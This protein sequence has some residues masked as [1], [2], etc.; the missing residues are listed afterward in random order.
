MIDFLG[1]QLDWIDVNYWFSIFNDWSLIYVI[2]PFFGIELIRYT[3]LRRLNKDLIFDSIANLITFGAFVVI[4]YI[5]GILAITKVYFWVH[6][7]LS[8]SHL[9][10]TWITIICCILLA[11][12]AYYWDHR[13]MHR[14]GLGWA[15]HTVHH[16]SLHF[17]MSVAYRFG[18]LDAIFP[19]IFSLPIVM[20]WG[21]SVLAG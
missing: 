20:L 6:E 14:I 19:I 11:D 4:E 8:L 12:F 10:L 9:P 16:S 1:K 5:L 15:T 17:N 7:H 2:L 21:Y 13:T 3:V 18:P